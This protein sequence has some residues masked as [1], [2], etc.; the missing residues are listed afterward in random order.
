MDWRFV[1]RC[2]IRFCASGGLIPAVCFSLLAQSGASQQSWQGRTVDEYNQRIEQLG[3]ENSAGDS[4]ASSGS[5]RQEVLEYRIGPNDV[6]SI[7]VFDAPDLDR[8]VRV[9]AGGEIT[10]P[11]LGT[12]DA[13]G[14]TP[15]ELEAAIADRLRAHYMRDPQV[16]VFVQEM[17]SHGVSVFGAVE[18]PGVYQIRGV[19]SLVEVLSLAQGIS[20]DA[21]DTVI[22]VRGSAAPEEMATT[23]EVDAG[24]ANPNGVTAVSGETVEVSLARLLDRP[25][26]QDN[27]LI[28]PGDV[29]KVTRAGVVYV[30]GEVHKPGGYVLNANQKISVLQ[31][32]ALAEGLTGTAARRRAVIIRTDAVTGQRTQIPI[33]LGKVL[34]GRTPDAQ[35]ES[36]DIVFVPNSAARTSLYRG[37]ETVVAMATGIVIYHLP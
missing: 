30:V 36:R 5:A 33:D 17:E 7:S 14:R 8:S 22:V 35:L 16:S 21:G 13:A 10:L 26:P 29:V 18:K 12:F 1:T 11:L 2:F 37:T 24:G 19:A 23:A 27:V 3:G 15:H 9:S 25:D 28:Y 32:L 4:T 20:E 31:A 34:A 6:V